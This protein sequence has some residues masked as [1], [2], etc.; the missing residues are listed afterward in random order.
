MRKTTTLQC[1]AG[2]ETPTSG[3]IEMGDTVVYCSK[4]NVLVPANR[5]RLRRRR[6]AG[7]STLRLLQ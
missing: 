3:R 5:R 2:L 1:V 7:T 4:R 6:L